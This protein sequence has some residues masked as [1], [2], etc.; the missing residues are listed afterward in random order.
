M[1]GDM[2]TGLKVA[3]KMGHFWRGLVGTAAMGMMFTGLGLLPL[4]EVT[5]I[6]FAAPILTVIF[7]AM[8]LNE[9][10]GVI[11]LSAV[12]LGLVGVLVVLSPR[13][14]AFSG[15]TVQTAQAMGGR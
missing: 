4:P 12:A 14:T 1:R 13:L 2:R 3:S 10:V 11:R 5:A 8:F 7:A 15:E 9:S 6:G